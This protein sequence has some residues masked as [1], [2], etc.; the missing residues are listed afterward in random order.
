MSNITTL[1]DPGAGGSADPS[2]PW[3]FWS[4]LAWA[5]L[6]FGLV[7]A[8]GVLWVGW[9]QADSIPDPQQDPWFPLQLI[10]INAVQVA[11]LVGAARL[12]GWPAGRYLGLVR[13][14]RRD[15]LV[16]IAALAILLGALEILTHVL[17][18][19]SVTPFQTD[20]YRAARG[21]GT[22]ALMWLAFVVAAPVG[23]EIM[24]R[25]FVFRGWA[26]SPLGAPGAIL[27]TSLIFAVVHTQYDWFGV[28][29]T[30][31]MGALFG[32][33]RWRSGSTAL[34]ILLHMLINFIA[35]VWTAA[36]VEGWV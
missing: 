7:L 17:G 20:A 14:S 12:A 15:V 27:L 2:R 28:F 5:L 33:L 34:T 18:R 9:S 23:E 24:F 8:G 31:C 26:A 30:L 10:F 35:T 11:V 29:Q 1:A 32:W 22:L 19:E 21:A 6:A 16:G 3:G 4:T 36:K 25:G 13:P